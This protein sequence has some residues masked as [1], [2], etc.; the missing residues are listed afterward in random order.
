MSHTVKTMKDL[1]QDLSA[2]PVEDIPNG[3][4]NGQSMGVEDTPKM[5]KNGRWRL[6]GRYCAPPTA[7]EPEPSKG[8]EKTTQQRAKRR[9]SRGINGKAPREQ[10]HVAHIIVAPSQRACVMRDMLAGGVLTWEDVWNTIHH[11]PWSN[12]ANYQMDVV[13][14]LNEMGAMGKATIDATE[15]T[16]LTAWDIE[17]NVKAMGWHIIQSNVGYDL[18]NNQ[19]HNRLMREFKDKKTA[20]QARWTNVLRYLADK[21]GNMDAS[22]FDAAFGAMPTVAQD[23]AIREWLSHYST[24]QDKEADGVRIQPDTPTFHVNHY[25]QYVQSRD[26]AL[27]DGNE[28]PSMMV[29]SFTGQRRRFYHNYEMASELY[30]ENNWNKEQ[31]RKERSELQSY[32][33]VKEAPEGGL[34]V[35]TF[36]PTPWKG[37]GASYM[38]RVQK[39]S[40]DLAKVLLNHGNLRELP[41]SIYLVDENGKMEAKGKSPRFAAVD[42]ARVHLFGK[43]VRKRLG[44]AWAGIPSVRRIGWW[45]SVKTAEFHSPEQQQVIYDFV[46]RPVSQRR[47][48]SPRLNKAARESVRMEMTDLEV[49]SE[50]VLA[51]A[52]DNNVPGKDVEVIWHQQ[53]RY[54]YLDLDEYLNAESDESAQGPSDKVMKAFFEGNLEGNLIF[55]NGHFTL[56]YTEEQKERVPK[57]SEKKSRRAPAHRRKAGARSH[58][59]KPKRN[60]R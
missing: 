50:E 52:K 26:R 17:D 35:W 46:T 12:D 16:P 5:D 10:R 24:E 3:V 48:P 40:N 32:W 54:D 7:S 13:R 27:R 29:W 51:W 14:A 19:E 34:A 41:K 9:K 2:G 23:A 60:K 43:R 33:F 20:A 6:N 36:V 31:A 42:P 44:A 15:M 58:R 11:S 39:V 25:N 56:P 57:H 53:M 1:Q 4:E 37:E 55:E 30:R 59:D 22:T 8:S 38:N 45:P 49:T 21:H 47:K 28:P 18:Y